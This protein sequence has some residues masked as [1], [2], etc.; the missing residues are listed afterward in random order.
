MTMM[1]QETKIQFLL[2]YL[3]KLMTLSQNGTICA[4]EINATMKELNVELGLNK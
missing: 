2:L 1:T 4:K 3:D